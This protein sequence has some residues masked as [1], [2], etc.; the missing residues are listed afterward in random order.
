MSCTLE[1]LLTFN[2]SRREKKKKK[3]KM[4]FKK[5]GRCLLWLFQKAEHNGFMKASL[6]MSPLTPEELVMAHK[7]QLA[8]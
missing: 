7:E 3:K 2:R 4:N 5:S 1:V 8:C 6:Q